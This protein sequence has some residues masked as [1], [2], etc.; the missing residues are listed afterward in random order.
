MGSPV[1]GGLQTKGRSGTHTVNP[2][3]K[4]KDNSSIGHVITSG[5][6]ASL[7]KTNKKDIIDKPA[8]LNMIGNSSKDVKK[9]NLDDD[10]E[11]VRQNVRDFWA[12]RQPTI[13][14]VPS[15]IAKSSKG[16]QGTSN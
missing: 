3:W 16:Q 10:S 12:K 13:N 4:S 5:D 9:V 2:G 14:E 6:N 11:K 15:I 1:G 8:D 7:S